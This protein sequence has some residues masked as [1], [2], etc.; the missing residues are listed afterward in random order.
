MNIF[1][2]RKMLWLAVTVMIGVGAIGVAETTPSESSESSGILQFLNQ[3]IIWYRQMDSLRQM[4]TE[5]EE[6]LLLNE[7]QQIANEAVSLAFDFAR[8]R[9]ESLGKQPASNQPDTENP[10]SS[11]YRALQRMSTTLD[12]QIRE[13]QLEI[14]SLRQKVVA[15]EGPQRQKLQA[16]IAEVQSE[17]DLATARR[18]ALHSMADFVA[19]S[20]I[21]GLGATDLR[22]QIEALARTVPAAMIKPSTKQQSAAE[23]LYPAPAA[24]APKSQP[25][26]VWGL[27]ADLFSLSPRMSTLSKDIDT[28]D[29]LNRQSAEMRTPL[30]KQL[31]DLSK[32]GDQL[33]NQA[34]SAGQAQLAQEKTQLDAL[35]KQF[36]A[37]SAAVL[38]LSRQGILFE[39][40][41]RNLA[42]WRSDLR[43]RYTTELRDLLVRVVA[44]VFLLAATIAAA[45]LWRRTIFRY[46]QDARRRHQNLL[47]RKIVLWFT[48]AVILVFSF[49]SEISS[50]A[51]FAGLLTAGVAV[52]L[53]NVILSI[54]GYF[55][56]IGKFGIRVGD[57]VQVAGVTGEV[58]DIGLVRFHMLEFI[59]GGDK[60]PSGRLVAFSNSIV[61]QSNAGLFKQIPGTNFVWHEV[62]VSVPSGGDYGSAEKRLRETLESVFS[63]YRDEM[64]KQYRQVHTT[65][66]VIPKDTLQPKSRLHFTDSGLEVVIRYPVDLLHAAEIDD[67]VTRELLK[68]AGPGSPNIKLRTDLSSTD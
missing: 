58:V 36:K 14:E 42:D 11:R 35:T 16:Q 15:A 30:V 22:E 5:P 60:T 65:L 48:I 62:T 38:P 45:E 39:E 31:R 33:A 4:A 7:N 68:A 40:Y 24:G 47:L 57:R 17:L 43:A 34:D 9:A 26:G 27:A 66:A 55:F 21:N 32:Q 19:G 52:A 49:A 37:A 6:L 3:T 13:T 20:S 23:Q 28:T 10:G 63:E 56:L 67:R 29:S 46:V 18:D 51:T 64:E 59:G 54:A 44:L 53:Q 41:K 1:W 50:A 2:Q 25:A 8:A 61:F 12:R